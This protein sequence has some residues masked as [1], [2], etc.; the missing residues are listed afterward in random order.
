MRVHTN[1]CADD[2][3][4]ETQYVEPDVKPIAYEG[5]DRSLKVQECSKG[6]S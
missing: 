5:G 2:G 6:M 1:V 3:G 4:L